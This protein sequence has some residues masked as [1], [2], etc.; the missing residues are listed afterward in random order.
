MLQGQ[1]DKLTDLVNAMQDQV[2]ASEN[3]ANAL[4]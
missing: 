3:I 1:I 2:R 4:S